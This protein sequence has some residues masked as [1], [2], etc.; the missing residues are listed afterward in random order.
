MI[1]RVPILG[2]AVIM[3]ATAALAQER[4]W[5]W[6]VSETEAYLVFGVPESEDVG[7]SFWCTQGTGEVR[8]FVADANVNLAADLDTSIELS[9]GGK[10]FTVKA[11]TMANELD[12]T[13]SA[14]GAIPAGDPVFPA[15][16]ETD[17]FVVSVAGESQTF[18]SAGEDFA[19][20][21]E[22]CGKP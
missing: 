12:A 9:A 16:Q 1:G 20:L 7:I 21:T 11:R 15:L 3:S 6:G 19:N 4:E 2:V 18:P 5:S 10:T 17:R 13:T 14:E 8:V 22:A